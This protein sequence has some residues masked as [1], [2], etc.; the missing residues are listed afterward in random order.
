MNKVLFVTFT[1]IIVSAANSFSQ[2]CHGGGSSSMAGMESPNIKENHSEMNAITQTI[3]PVMGNTINREIFAD[4]NGNKKNTP[5]RVYFCCADC[6]DKF[7]KKPEKYVN[8]LLK[9]KQPVE[10]IFVTP[11]Q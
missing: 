9:M 4:W 3:C 7:Q 11:I 6:I 2:S 5:K 1:A 10:N 8:K